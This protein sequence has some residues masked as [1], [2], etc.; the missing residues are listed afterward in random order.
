MI[1]AALQMTELP[2]GIR[3]A[4]NSNQHT[5]HWRHTGPTCVF[6]I[7][8]H[9]RSGP[10]SSNHIL[11]T[12]SSGKQAHRRGIH[13]IHEILLSGMN[14]RALAISSEIE[15]GP[16]SV[17]MRRQQIPDSFERSTSPAV[18]VENCRDPELAMVNVGNHRHA[19]VPGAISPN[20]G[21]INTA[22]ASGETLPIPVSIVPNT[23]GNFMFPPEPGKDLSEP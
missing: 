8:K 13:I 16:K 21:H 15:R 12:E 1:I 5:F 14:K 9:I 18:E 3:I 19:I 4:S 6:L 10:S 17:D 22:S 7:F 2:N 20:S 23:L 11:S